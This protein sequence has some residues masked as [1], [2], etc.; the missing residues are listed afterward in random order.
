MESES[1]FPPYK[2]W[3]A[4]LLEGSEWNP[5]VFVLTSR[6]QWV[7]SKLQTCRSRHLWEFGT[8]RAKVWELCRLILKSRHH[9]SLHWSP[10]VQ[11]KPPK[12]QPWPKGSNISNKSSSK[13][14]VCF[15]SSI[16]CHAPTFKK[17][18][19]TWKVI[20]LVFVVKSSALGIVKL[21]VYTW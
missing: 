18:V 2:K 11:M 12:C 20:V 1:E 15:L 4:D 9:N 13:D 17:F 3:N 16:R 8:T 21:F 14:W 5:H 19:Y 6:V 7:E 10:F